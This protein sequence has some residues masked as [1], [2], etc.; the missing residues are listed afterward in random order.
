MAGR[1]HSK[2]Q[3]VA[4]HVAHRTRLRVPK[5]HRTPHKM[6]KA[7]DALRK[8]PGVNHVEVNHR[9]GSILVHHDEHP[10]ILE[11]VEKTLEESSTEL[12]EALVEGGNP[13]VLGLAVGFHLISNLFSSADQKVSKAT[14]NL[15]DAKTIAPL[16]FLVAGFMRL[17]RGSGEDVLMTISPVV[18][19]FYAFDLYWRFNVAGPTAEP[20]A[21]TEDGPATKAGRKQLKAH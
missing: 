15:V 1:L 10:G 7:A 9:T 6:D 14:N 8:T 2:S 4:H 16:A 21:V 3:G 18:L 17:R 13:E 11:S 5:S 19:F 20:Q 12:L